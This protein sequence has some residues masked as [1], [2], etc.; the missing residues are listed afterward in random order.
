MDYPMLIDGALVDGSRRLDV[1]DPSTGEVF[2][3]CACASAADIDAAVAAAAAAFPKW[4]GTS[5]E[6]R[7]ALMLKMAEAIEANIDTLARTLARI[8]VPLGIL[9][10]IVGAPFFL[11]LLWR[12]RHGWS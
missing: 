10:A 3:H 4:S 6:T 12:G 5:I 1:V 11:W 9:T 8:E 7:H 2:A